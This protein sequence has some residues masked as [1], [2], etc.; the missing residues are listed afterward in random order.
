M[1]DRS[2]T[3]RPCN[4]MQQSSE[5]DLVFKTPQGKVHHQYF[6]ILGRE[7]QADSAKLGLVVGKKNISKAVQRNRFKRIARESYRLQETRNCD[8]VILA[9]KVSSTV[10]NYQLRSAFDSALATLKQKLSGPLHG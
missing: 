10:T 1:N 8:V 6:L 7:Q 4:R 9:K 3:L 5:F 2:N